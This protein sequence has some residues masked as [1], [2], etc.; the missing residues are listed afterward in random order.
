MGGYFQ[1][2]IFWFCIS[3]GT[4]SSCASITVIKLSGLGIGR[5][6]LAVLELHTAGVGEPFEPRPG[7]VLVANSADEIPQLPYHLQN[8]KV[9]Q[10]VALFITKSVEVQVHEKEMK[11]MI[12]SRL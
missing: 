7:V 10:Q 4:C 3:V 8:S 2:D 6:A 12:L 9:R 5:T 11:M 1:N